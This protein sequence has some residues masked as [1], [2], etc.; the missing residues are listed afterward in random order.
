MHDDTRTN[1]LH[2]GFPKQVCLPICFLKIPQGP[3]TPRLAAFLFQSW[4]RLGQGLGFHIVRVRVFALGSAW[5]TDLGLN[6]QL[7]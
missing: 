2:T 3:N 4:L 6:I 1:V 5:L 7:D